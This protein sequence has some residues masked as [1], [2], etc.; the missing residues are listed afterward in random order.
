MQGD[1]M[2]IFA[3]LIGIGLVAADVHDLGAR[4][5]SRG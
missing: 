5:R 3:L 4:K 1:R 2:V